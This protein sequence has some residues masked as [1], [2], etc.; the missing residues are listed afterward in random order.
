MKFLF[1]MLS[2]LLISGCANQYPNQ[3]PI[4][5][6]F[7]EISGETLEQQTVQMPRHFNG[8][9]T[10]LLVGYKQDSQFDIDR[11]L[12][13]LDMTNTVVDAYELPTIGGMFPRMFETV[14]NNGMR[15]GIPKELWQGVITVYQDGDTLQ[16][17]TGNQNPRNTRVILLD[18][19][20]R[21]IYFNDVGFSVAGLNALR[22]A[23]GQ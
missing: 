1:I 17:F 12:I 20:H 8:D 4:G 14:I 6:N 22:A 10:V 16:A 19:N 18:K 9:Y 21:I 11:W 5:Q 13:G 23:M 3:N 15:A 2:L 7:P